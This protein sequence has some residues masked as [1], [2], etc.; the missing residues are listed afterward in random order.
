MAKAAGDVRR[1]G[2]FFAIVPVQC[3][4]HGRLLLGHASAWRGAVCLGAG[5]ME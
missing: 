1:I 4:E 3:N 2:L 5:S